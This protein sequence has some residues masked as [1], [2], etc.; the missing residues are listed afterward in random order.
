MFDIILDDIF[1]SPVPSEHWS[2]CPNQRE[3]P[4]G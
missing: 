3:E 1:I 4:E 2:D